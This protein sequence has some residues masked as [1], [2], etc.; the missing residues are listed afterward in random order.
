M[1]P[2]SAQF[3]RLL[4]VWIV[5][6]GVAFVGGL[7]IVAALLPA[8]PAPELGL[9]DLESD[10]PSPQEEAAVKLLAVGDI[11]SCE[12]QADEAV[13]E[14]AG[15]LRGEIA[16]LGDIA[17][18]SGTPEQFAE[19][20]DP[21]WS[22]LRDRLHPTPGNHDYQ[23][24]DAAGYFEYFGDAAG[25]PGEGWYTWEHGAWQLLAINSICEPVGG[26]GPDSP[27]V[28]WIET[29][30]AETDASCTLAYFHH[31]RYSSGKHGDA[32]FMEPIWQALVDGG[33]DLTLA[34][35]DHT[36]ERLL[37]D[38]VR[39]F[40]VGTGGRSLYEFE[41]PSPFSETRSNQAYGLLEL[42]LREDGYDW[43]YITLGSSGFL[44]SGS[45]EC[46]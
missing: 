8:E 25:T 27:Q 24:E 32:P 19:C 3:R 28:D 38:G 35:H 36:Y 23:T 1:H 20:F 12:G 5:A 26:C 16:L 22:P 40:V 21:A 7:M 39:S 6:A 31:P 18:D 2:R 15:R 45:G 33:I 29:T 41:H 42:T 30:L 46:R 34:G 17:Y 13:A 37:A 43:R 11:G 14:L 9:P 4:A 44:D 10:P